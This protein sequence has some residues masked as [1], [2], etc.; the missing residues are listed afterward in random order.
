MTAAQPPIDQ[1][2]LVGLRH[3]DDRSL[4]Q[5]F[6]DRYPGLLQEAAKEL[7][8]PAGAPRVVERAFLRVWDE[9]EKFETRQALDTFIRSAVHDSAT[10]ERKRMATL[11]RFEAGAHVNVAHNTTAAPPSA[12]EAWLHLK[13]CLHPDAPDA[14]A[15]ARAQATHLQR[16]DAAEH[17]KSIGKRKVPWGML[18]V[19]AGVALLVAAPLWW[20]EQS[21]TDA[22]ANRALASSNARVYNTVTGQQAAITL[23]D[24]SQA[25]LGADT[26]LVIA[27]DFG[28][29]VRAVKLEG[30]ALFTVAPAQKHEFYVRA[31]DARVTATGTTFGVHAFLGDETVVVGVREGGVTVKTEDATRDVTAPNGVIVTKNGEI[32]DATPAELDEAL[33]W[34][35]DR[36]AVAERPLRDALKRINRWY[37]M[38]LVVR[39]SALLARPVTVKSSLQSSRDAI[40][41][42]EKTGRLKFGYEGKTM[43]L[44]D[45]GPATK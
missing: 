12:D 45:A 36:F 8:N 38:E 3:G 6:R 29:T 5:L 37:A 19:G 10:R 31:A 4:E 14:H 42:L 20:A 43:V 26:K 18:A 1:D 13:A 28:T 40:A 32:R 24:G 30:A 21:G 27:P 11:H 41:G 7:D 25:K 39:D 2:V 9:R 35:E 17:V 44:T 22:A 16:H 23:L 15:A 33:G 34:T